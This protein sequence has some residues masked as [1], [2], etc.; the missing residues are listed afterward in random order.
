M[1]E[2]VISKLMELTGDFD[3]SVRDSAFRSIRRLKFIIPPAMIDEVESALEFY[4]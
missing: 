4:E 1:S 3:P 2:K